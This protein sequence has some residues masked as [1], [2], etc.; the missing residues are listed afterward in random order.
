MFI[1]LG[2]KRLMVNGEAGIPSQN[3]VKVV[4]G[5]FRFDQDLALT[6]HQKM[7][8]KVVKDQPQRAKSATSTFVRSMVNGE[9]GLL[10]VLAVK[11]VVGDFRFDQ[12]L[13]IIHH[14]NMEEKIV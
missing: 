6:H 5:D 11:V 13:V 3:A 14:Q 2:I 4:V 7:E 10:L 1:T 9:I 8:E 12:E